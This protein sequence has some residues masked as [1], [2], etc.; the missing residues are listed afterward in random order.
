MFACRWY[1]WVILAQ[2]TAIIACTLF[3]TDASQQAMAISLILT[4]AIKMHVQYVP[5]VSHGHRHNEDVK[6]FRKRW[7]YQ[8]TRGD[9]LQ[10]QCLVCDLGVALMGLVCI[11]TRYKYALRVCPLVLCSCDLT[12]CCITG[13]ISSLRKSTRS[14]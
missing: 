6:G 12:R 14:S 4:W 13:G 8:A 1:E 3:I 7:H 2:R 11:N 5:F 9:K 10:L